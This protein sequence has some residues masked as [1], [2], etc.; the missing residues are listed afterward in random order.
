MGNDTPSHLLS[1]PSSSARFILFELTPCVR[2]DHSIRGSSY[3]AG[4]QDTPLILG[5]AIL[6]RH[7]VGIDVFQCDGS[8]IRVSNNMHHF[9]TFCLP[10]SIVLGYGAV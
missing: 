3:L 8:G 6:R 7:V 1:V 10:F 5:A 9:I 2:L 4:P